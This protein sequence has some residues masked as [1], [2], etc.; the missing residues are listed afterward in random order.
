MIVRVAHDDDPLEEKPYYGEY[1]PLLRVYSET[2]D[3]AERYGRE[4]DTLER[5]M[6]AL[7]AHILEDW[8]ATRRRNHALHLAALELVKDGVIDHLCLTLDDTSK[9]GL[10]A[11]DRRALEAKIDALGV[12]SQVDI[13]PGADEVS[14]TLLARLLQVKSQRESTQ[15]YVRYTGMRG[16]AA[17]LIYEDRPVGELV[18]AQLRAAGC[19]QVDTLSE[20]DLVLAVNTPATKQA[21]VQPDYATVDTPERH[22]PDFVDFIRICLEAHK[23]VSIADIAYP[24]GAERRLMRLLDALPSFSISRSPS[25]L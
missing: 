23:P 2:F 25:R 11:H 15:V 19:Q 12:W 16:A 9:D 22:L 8:L 17:E 1:G 4:K 3:R 20:A 14:V 24:N 7:P 6:E 18:K 21:E 13:Y 5:A 10:A